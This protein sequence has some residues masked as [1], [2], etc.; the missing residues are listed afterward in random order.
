MIYSIHNVWKGKYEIE[1]FPGEEICQGC[2]GTGVSAINDHWQI[3]CR[4]CHG[5]GKIDWISNV[6]GEK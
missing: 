2:K 5:E 6:I 4:K 3:Q 1:L